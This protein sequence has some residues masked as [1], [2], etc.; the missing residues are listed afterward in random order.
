M[1]SLSCKML[2]VLGPNSRSFGLYVKC[3][4]PVKIGFDTNLKYPI[5]LQA[6]V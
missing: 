2:S 3:L 1:P 6:A 5:T 4:V